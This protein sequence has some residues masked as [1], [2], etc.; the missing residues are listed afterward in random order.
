MSQVATL[1]GAAPSA[2]AVGAS[3]KTI[4]AFAAVEAGGS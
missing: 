1:V 2:P 4:E 3:G